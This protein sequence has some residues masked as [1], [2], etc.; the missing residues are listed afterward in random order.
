MRLVACALST[1]LL[2]GCSWLGIGGDS[3]GKHQAYE[4]SNSGH[5]AA[6]SGQA[7]LGPCQISSP[8]QAVPQGCRPEQVTLALGGQQSA[9]YGQTQ[10]A[11]AGYGSHA[12]NAAASTQYHTP[13][14]RVKR[15]WL[16]GSLGMEIDHSVGGNLYSPSAAL[17]AAGYDRALFAEGSTTGSVADGTTTSTLY[18]SSNARLGMINAPDISF[19]DV[20]TAPLRITGGVELI[21][22]DHATVFAN[23]GFTRA[24]GKK[25]GGA[26][27]NEELL[28]TVTVTDYNTD[29]LA[30]PLGAVT[31]MTSNT[32]FIPNETVATFDYEFN[33]LEKVDF[34]I[35]GRYYFDPMFPGHFERTITPFVAASGGAAYYSETTVV[36]NQ[37]QRYLERAFEG[38]QI[39]SN[40]DFYDVSFGVPTQIYDSQWTP[41]GSIKGGIEWQMT[42]KT[43]LAVEA[44]VKYEGARDFSDGTEGDNIISVPI[45]IRGSYNF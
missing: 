45:A 26:E 4:S 12:G 11:T 1:V 10:Y 20:Y 14:K 41:Y 9:Q 34:E 37:R 21:M 38:T 25:G 22:S 32:T 15:P 17:S 31:G 40:G 2:S 13:K 18:T 43:A 6:K 36:E 5:Y 39:S 23:A 29:P 19:D 44:G 24:E 27:I 7:R 16:R 35:G 8:M 30:G 3:H 33:E 28:R 42:P